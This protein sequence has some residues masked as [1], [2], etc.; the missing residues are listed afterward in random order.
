MT[1]STDLRREGGVAVII[2]IE[3]LA[4]GLQSE[5]DD[6]QLLDIE[7]IVDFAEEYGTIALMRAYGDWRSRVVN[8]HQEALYKAGIELV[9]VLDRVGNQLRKNSA[10]V[11]MAVDAMECI[12]TLPHIET[13][14]IVSGDRDFIHVL[15]ALRRYGK[16]VIGLSADKSASADFARLCDRFMKYSSLIGSSESSQEARRPSHNAEFRRLA[17]SVAGIVGDRPEGTLGTS[18]KQALRREQPKFDESEFG[19]RNFTSFLEAL[20]IR[21]NI[22]KPDTGDIRVTLGEGQETLPPT[23]DSARAHR[24]RSLIRRCGLH[25]SRFIEERDLRVR[26]IEELYQRAAEQA[27]FRMGEVSEA[28]TD[29]LDL[30]ITQLAKAWALLY[31][32]RSM[33]FDPDDADLPQKQRRASFA[34]SIEGPEDLLSAYESIALFRLRCQEDGD[35]RE[36]DDAL[37]LGLDPE[38]ADTTALLEDRRRLAQEHLDRRNASS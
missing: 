6:I 35:I 13:Y 31:Q 9:H 29:E 15:K 5:Q 25:Q 34:D 12:W 26:L 18:I 36:S 32:A 17:N 3:N 2:D 10:D 21:L 38:D 16:Q 20:P 37:I 30:S 27:P 14:L 7:A 33:N 23:D 11:R 28:L 4:Y 24:R 19:F 22:V 8:Q 1:D